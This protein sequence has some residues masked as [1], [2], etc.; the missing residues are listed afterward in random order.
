MRYCSFDQLELCTTS[1]KFGEITNSLVPI[2]G[3]KMARNVIAM[4]T[5]DATAELTST[6]LPEIVKQVQE[7][8]SFSTHFI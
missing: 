6:E 4:A 5:G 8:V 2:S 7:A 1:I 3:R